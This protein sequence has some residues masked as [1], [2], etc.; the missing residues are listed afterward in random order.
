MFKSVDFVESAWLCLLNIKRP[1]DFVASVYGTLQQ[2]LCHSSS[3]DQRWRRWP[4]RLADSVITGKLR[5]DINFTTINTGLQPS[6][7]PV[8]VH[9]WHNV[10]ATLPGK[11]YKRTP[12][13][14]TIW[15]E[16]TK[17][18]DACTNREL[19]LVSAAEATWCQ[20]ISAINT[21]RT[22]TLETAFELITNDIRYCTLRA[23]ANG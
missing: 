13:D 14:N 15:R 23:K 17:P 10:T 8:T 1:F 22:S 20:Y 11:N 6:A 3:Y 19:Q 18:S 5:L 2:Q 21:H 4:L 9:Q 7:E 16:I 12:I